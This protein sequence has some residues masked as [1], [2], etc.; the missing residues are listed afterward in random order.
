VALLALGCASPAPLGEPAPAARPPATGAVRVEL[1]FGAEAD[2]DLFVTDPWYEEVYFGNSP[3]LLGGV[4][5]GDRRC[6][7]PAPR[8]EAVHFSP[9]PAGFYRVSVDYPIRCQG[10][11]DEVPYRVVVEAGGERQVYERRAIFGATDL[12]V[13]FEVPAF[14]R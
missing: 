12:V 2:L 10:G 6:G 3:S 14:P 13:D 11:I 4:F 8:V 1:E 9:A 7:D 5:E